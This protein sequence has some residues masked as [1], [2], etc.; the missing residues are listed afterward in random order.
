MKNDFLWLLVLFWLAAPVYA[1][2]TADPFED[3]YQY[4]LFYEFTYQANVVESLLLECTGERAVSYKFAFAT[5]P[6][7]NSYKREILGLDGLVPDP[8]TGKPLKRLYDEIRLM[9]SRDHTSDDADARSAA[10]PVLMAQK[11]V[12]RLMAEFPEEKDAL[13]DFVFWEEVIAFEAATEK[14][15]Q[16]AKTRKRT[17]IQHAAFNEATEK[18][19]V[20]LNRLFDANPL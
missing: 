20:V 5:A 4:E 8:F 7:S 17:S 13:C 11:D 15:L 1:D 16:D 6:I 14:L 10:E 18:G 2:G 9:F 3:Q 12:L 19:L